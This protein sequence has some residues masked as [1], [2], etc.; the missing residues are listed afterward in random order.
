MRIK[1]VMPVI[2][3]EAECR[4][5]E[6][7]IYED[8]GLRPDTKIEFVRILKGPNYLSYYT[9]CLDSEYNVLLEASKAEQEGYDAVQPDCVF[10]PAARALKEVLNIP[11]VAPLECSLHLASLL[12]RKISILINEKEMIRFIEDKVREYGFEQKVVSIKVTD[13]TYDEL[14]FISGQRD[15][16]AIDRK[17][18]AIGTKA[19]EED[20]ADVLIYA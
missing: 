5:R 17:L 1:G 10:D 7:G 2:V 16:D 13:I 12:G 4:R 18:I 6:Q 14:G 11:V 19:I 9:E 3:S 8:A 20:G 15:K